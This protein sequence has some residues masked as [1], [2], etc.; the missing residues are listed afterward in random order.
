MTEHERHVTGQLRGSDQV[1][2]LDYDGVLH[3]DAVFRTKRGLELRAPGHLLMHASILAEILADFPAVRISLSTSWVRT[4]GFRRAR[5]V[6]PPALQARTVSATW[7]SS[8]LRAPLLG[9]DLQTRYEQILSA[10]AAARLTSWLALD[11]DPQGSWP[12]HDPR[13]VR[14]NSQHGLADTHV[15]TELYNRLRQMAKN[16]RDRSD[17][18]PGSIQ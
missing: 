11:D 9:Y 2:F 6:L 8:M 10:V 4:L 7:H 5:A 16:K 17:W 15:Q 12:E 13:L 3:P 1:L 14:C 18:P